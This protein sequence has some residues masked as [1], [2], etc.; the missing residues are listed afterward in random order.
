MKVFLIGY[1][2]SGK[3]TVGKKLA[4]KLNLQFIDL[5]AYIEQREGKTIPQIFA[6]QGEP[7]F[8][9]IEHESLAEVAATNDAVISTG[10]GAPCFYNNMDIINKNGIS[11]YLKMNVN[12]LV[13]RLLRAKEERPLIVNKSEQELAE[14][15]TESLRERQTYYSL[16]KLVVN[17]KSL[18]S[19]GIE[20]LARAVQMF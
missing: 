13:Q 16:A 14:Y 19:N 11:I 2:G 20:E 17:A 4:A 12:A 3:S 7:A 10:G 18:D 5:D 6:E 15:I 9:E 8:R 1:M